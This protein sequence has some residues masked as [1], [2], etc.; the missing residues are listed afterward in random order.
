MAYMNLTA[1]PIPRSSLFL[2]PRVDW[3]LLS[4]RIALGP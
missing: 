2:F 3:P 1:F 4:A